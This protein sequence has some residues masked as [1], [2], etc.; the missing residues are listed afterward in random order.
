[1]GQESKH[2]DNCSSSYQKLKQT[3]SFGHA[4]HMHSKINYKIHNNSPKIVN[5]LPCITI[6]P[7]NIYSSISCIIESSEGDVYHKTMHTEGGFLDAGRLTL[8]RSLHNLSLQQST[9]PA[10][11]RCSEL[12][13]PRAHCN[14]TRSD[15]THNTHNKAPTQRN[16][17]QARE[18]DNPKLCEVK[19]T[20]T[21]A[22]HDGWGFVGDEIP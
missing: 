6:M 14:Q 16:Q 4:V 22:R 19:L 2:F 13:P 17:H 11:Q 7:S 3:S 21:S 8:T 9:V 20:F 1:M 5:L 10:S 18:E 12:T 15:P